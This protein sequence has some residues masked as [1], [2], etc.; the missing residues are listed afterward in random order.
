MVL[1]FRVQGKPISYQSGL[2]KWP[3]DR[4]G[5]SNLLFVIRENLKVAAVVL[6]ILIVGCVSNRPF[7]ESKTSFGTVIGRVLYMNGEPVRS[8]TVN[9]FELIE[10]N[11]KDFFYPYMKIKFEIAATTVTDRNGRFIFEQVKSGRYSVT[12]KEMQGGMFQVPLGE[13]MRVLGGRVTDFGDI[14]VA[15]E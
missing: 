6:L 1:R 11:E 13:D 2:T 3:K 14:S 15:V 7:V 9:L 5:R 8:Q 12:A 10:R 4:V